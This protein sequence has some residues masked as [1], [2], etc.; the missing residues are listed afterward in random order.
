MWWVVV[1]EVAW[2]MIG[3]TLGVSK[4]LAHTMVFFHGPT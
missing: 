4:G 3:Q 1:A 2:G